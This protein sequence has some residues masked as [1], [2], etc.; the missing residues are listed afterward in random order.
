MCLGGRAFLCYFENY[1]KVIHPFEFMNKAVALVKKCLENQEPVLDLGNCG[2]SDYEFA[3]DEELGI[4][5]AQCTHVTSFILSNELRAW[6]L[7]EDIPLVYHPDV[8]RTEQFWESPGPKFSN[9]F[10]YRMPERF[11][12]PPLFRPVIRESD[13]EPRNKNKLRKIPAVIG[14]MVNL[15]VFMYGGE[16]RDPWITES[17]EPLKGL[18]KLKVLNLSYNRIEEFGI[19]HW[20]P[21]LE[22][23]D[24]SNNKI[25]RIFGFHHHNCLKFLDLSGN[26]LKSDYGIDKC[27]QLIWLSLANN[28]ISSVFYLDRN[29]LLQFLDISDNTIT[30]FRTLRDN[31]TL[32][33]LNISNNR[34]EELD[35]FDKLI[36]IRSLY[37]RGIEIKKIDPLNRCEELTLLDVSNNFLFRLP[38][39]LAGW[40]KLEFLDISNN[41]FRHLECLK[42]CE[43]LSV[44]NASG[45]FISAILNDQLP[46]SLEKL[47][48]NNNNERLSKLEGLSHLP[49]LKEL[50]AAENI[51]SDIDFA[52]QSALQVVVLYKNNIKDLEAFRHCS[53][54]AYLDVGK[55][56]LLN[57][58]PLTNH[59][60]LSV[61]YADYNHLSG[62]LSLNHFSKLH[63]ADLSANKIESVED[64][65]GLHHLKRIFLYDNL[66]E[67]IGCLKDLPELRII[68]VRRN[69]IKDLDEIQLLPKL[70]YLDASENKVKSLP[71]LKLF[72]GLR[73]LYLSANSIRSLKGLYH[74]PSL[75]ELYLDENWIKVIYDIE[76][77]IHFKYFD[78]CRNPIRKV[79][80]MAQM[81]RKY[82]WIFL[83]FN[84]NDALEIKSIDT[85]LLLKAPYFN[86]PRE[87]RND[88]YKSIR[89]W[90]IARD[91]GGYLNMEA[92]CILFGNGETGKTALSHYLRTGEFYEINDRTHGILIE[93]WETD[94]S[95][96]PFELQDN[97]LQSLGNSHSRKKLL[98]FRS[99]ALINIW[100]FGGQEFYHA[101]HRL[102]MSK[103]VLYLVLWQPETDFQNEQT[104]DFPKEYWI[105]NIQHYSPGAEMLMVQNMANEESYEKKDKMYKISLHDKW[106]EERVTQYHLDMKKLKE[107]ILR[108]VTTSPQFS[109]YIPL[110]YQRIKDKLEE[111]E[112]PFISYSEYEELCEQN[113]EDGDEIMKDVS[114]QDSLMRYLDNIGSVVCFRCRDRLKDEILKDYVFLDP[115]WLTTVIYEILK[116]GCHEFGIDHVTKI[117]KKYNLE[118]D[119]WVKI[120]KN[121]GLIFEVKTKKGI[122]YVVPQYLPRECGNEQALEMGLKGKD[123]PHSFTMRYPKFMPNSNF[124]RLISYYG[125]ENVDHVYWK[126]GVLFFHNNQTV[127][128]RCVN[129]IEER[130]ISVSVQ[131]ND[132]DTVA[133]ILNCIYDI[134]PNE[135][136]EISVDEEKYM[137]FPVLKKKI[138]EGRQEV[139]TLC[140]QTLLT[141]D[142]R[143]LFKKEK[144]VKAE[145][146]P[147]KTVRIFV[148]YASQDLLLQE[149]LIEGVK[150]HLYD[151]PGFE[152][153]HWTEGVVDD[154]A[155]S[156]NI[157][158]M[159][160]IKKAD[161]TIL[162]VSAKYKYFG[163]NG[164]QRMREFFQK[165]KE[166]GF[167]ML[168]VSLRSHDH[169]MGKSLWGV[170]FFQAKYGDYGFEMPVYRNKFMPFDVLAEDKNTTDQQ[171]NNYYKNLADEIYK[172]VAAKFLIES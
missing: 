58:D 93:K 51:L 172:A 101:T 121:F 154:L 22:E 49:N 2:L 133:D 136:L 18:H 4:L 74:H 150:T 164:T 159:R 99:T 87:I 82:E 27:P 3:M 163:T 8:K 128:A 132:S 86:V 156:W 103:D 109:M 100:D 146:P 36:N 57:L 127:F 123:M 72:P 149:L 50:Y 12:K 69:K 135:Q 85:K 134:D 31:T 10:E 21:L 55:N 5:L 88:G 144:I 34:I 138:E 59:Q 116:K 148:S 48:I 81:L 24:V 60:N 43:E 37:A 16:E 115:R 19:L 165:L 56:Q 68:D 35:Y 7:D 168:P 152:F 118:A 92:R 97:I 145:I 1:I 125:S 14:T 151:R 9:R 147:K 112:E 29:S 171:L 64:I 129:T 15:E 6:N 66:I 162:L 63:H 158:M 75:E 42:N 105:D 40:R 142:F 137:L 62:A 25:Q 76:S 169:R 139:D 130:K 96:F 108:K 77:L 45:N 167:L 52:T 46:D 83:S 28:L 153:T 161:L 79:Y 67:V 155:E 20:F 78:L 114:Q 95:D 113:D 91:N 111:F 71:N 32:K 84:Q 30:A 143:F 170:P 104:G 94:F 65:E 90:F 157:E 89:N 122:R 61:L 110:P 70:F 160:K 47:I 117:V 126:N 13:S 102:F 98:K 41:N 11:F 39:D 106:D 73:Q 26:Q 80:G 124:L 54:L 120:M 23:L 119:L 166:D 131:N 107:G 44:L 17:F 38:P 33:R 141:D 53:A 140:G